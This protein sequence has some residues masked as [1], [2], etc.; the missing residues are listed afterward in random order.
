MTVDEVRARRK[1]LQQE[2]TAGGHDYCFEGD[3]AWYP[4]RDE[5]V[6]DILHAIAADPNRNDAHLLAKEALRLFE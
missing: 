5:L 1:S 3:C 4:K 6:H 2:F